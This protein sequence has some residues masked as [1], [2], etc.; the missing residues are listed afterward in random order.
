MFGVAINFF[1][2]SILA[3][4]RPA[5]PHYHD[6]SSRPTTVPQPA[7]R[8][9]ARTHDQNL[10][11]LQVIMHQYLLCVLTQCATLQSLMVLRLYKLVNQRV[12]L[13]CCVKHVMSHRLTLK[14]AV[15]KRHNKISLM[16]FC[17]SNWEFDQPGSIWHFMCFVS[18]LFF[19]SFCLKILPRSV[20][21]FLR[22][23]RKV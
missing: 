13:C 3:G 20:W 15:E 22:T 7:D 16:I 17:S 5:D 2:R 12:N 4:R 19:S 9:L 1:Q 14:N 10:F 8:L 18:F 21:C 23:L 11:L 6:V